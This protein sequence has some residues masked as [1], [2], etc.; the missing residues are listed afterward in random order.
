VKDASVLQEAARYV[1]LAL[2]SPF[3]ALASR[4]TNYSLVSRQ[5]C[6]ILSEKNRRSLTKDPVSGRD[7]VTAA[8]GCGCQ[9]DGIDWLERRANQNA[10]DRLLFIRWFLASLRFIINHG[11][12]LGSILAGTQS[13]PSQQQPLAD[14]CWRQVLE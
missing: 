11:V 5:R 14:H 9:A 2:K 10:A 3:N 4:K 13:V 8:A 1:L 6:R 7:A 12:S